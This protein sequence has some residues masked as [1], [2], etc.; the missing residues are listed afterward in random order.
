MQSGYVN[1][2]YSKLAKSYIYLIT[3]MRVLPNCNNSGFQLRPF[4]IAVQLI[5]YI[6]H[7]RFVCEQLCSDHR[8]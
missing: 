1:V 8:V 3:Y 4:G 2:Y 5:L 6:R 7:N